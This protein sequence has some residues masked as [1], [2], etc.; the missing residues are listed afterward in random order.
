MHYCST[1]SQRKKSLRE[2][3]CFF[4]YVGCIY[5]FMMYLI[6]SCPFYNLTSCVSCN[7]ANLLGKMAPIPSWEEGCCLCTKKGESLRHR[8]SRES[9]LQTQNCFSCVLLYHTMVVYTTVLFA[10]KFW[11]MSWYVIEGVISMEVLALVTFLQH[12]LFFLHASYSIFTH[13]TL[14]NV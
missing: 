12:C 9:M 10:H 14:C 3:S 5:N 11:R 7:S 13:T 2:R 1:M 4:T 6:I 8:C